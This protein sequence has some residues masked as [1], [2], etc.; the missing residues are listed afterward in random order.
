MLHLSPSY[1]LSLFVCVCACTVCAP[2]SVR[3]IWQHNSQRFSSCKRA[4]ARFIQRRV[5]AISELSNNIWPAL[6]M[7]THMHTHMHI[8]MYVRVYAHGCACMTP[9]ARL[10]RFHFCFLWQI[11]IHSHMYGL[12]HTLPCSAL[13]WPGLAQAALGECVINIF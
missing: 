4:E 10:L 6:H 5:Y 1:F 3:N 8:C 12:L 11:S 2:F 7:L 9:K 13:V